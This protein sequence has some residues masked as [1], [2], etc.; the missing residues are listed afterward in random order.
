MTF[1]MP[2]LASK[3]R[4]YCLSSYLFHSKYK[5]LCADGVTRQKQLQLGQ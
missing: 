2:N 5:A 3:A 4:I 1:L